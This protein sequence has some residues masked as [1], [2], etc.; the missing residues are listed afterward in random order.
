MEINMKR[1]GD[2]QELQI[3]L[4]SFNAILEDQGRVKPEP[5][6]HYDWSN[7]DADYYHMNGLIHA[8]RN[9]SLGIN[10]PMCN[11]CIEGYEYVREGIH[12]NA[13]SCRNCGKLRKA[14]NRLLCAG[15][16]NDALNACISSYEFDSPNQQGAFY[17]LMNWDGQSSP[18]SFMMYGQPGN[19]KSTLLYII[20]KHKTAD[21]FKVK[22]AH[23][24]RTFEAEKNSWGRKSGSSHLDYFLHDVDVLLLDEFGG[25]GGGVKKYSDWFRNT[26]IE[27]IGS[28]Y[29]RWKAGRMAVIITT[30]IF[31]KALKETLFEDNYAV[32]S[33]LQEMFQHPIL[34]KGPDRR[35]P[36]NKHSVWGQ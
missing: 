35:R 34:I 8:G 32:L 29:E 23:H 28:I 30:N 11:S 9:R 21:G 17:E 22:Y 26:S 33:R 13:I 15:L 18:P 7:F 1:L 36:L 6:A 2:N 5:P 16:P 25:L 20:A 3:L 10:D 27:F 12:P 4:H 14:L 24:Y 31:P 19:G